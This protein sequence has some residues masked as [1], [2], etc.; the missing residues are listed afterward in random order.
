VLALGPGF[1]LAVDSTGS[2]TASPGQ[3]RL[4]AD[5]SPRPAAPPASSAAAQATSPYAGPV[6]P[7][8]ELGPPPQRL[9]VPDL[10]VIDPA[11]MTDAQISTVSK[12]DGVRAV[13]PA[14]GGQVRVNG[15]PAAVLG[16]LPQEFRSW[17]PPVT[18]ANLAVWAALT[19]G[20]MVTT[21]DAAR[22]LG[23]ATGIA[24]PVSGRD[25]AAIPFGIAAL[26]GVGG[27]DLVMD[28]DRSRQLGLIPDAVLLVNAPSANL[29]ELTRHISRVLGHAAKLVTLIPAATSAIP[30]ATPAIPAA[31]PAIPAATPAGLPVDARVSSGQP[32]GYLQLFQE[33]AARY[34]PGLSWT[35]LAAIG[36]IESGDGSND[37]PSTAGALG[38]MQFMPSTWT[39]WGTDGFGQTG[40][41]D[42][43]NPLDAVPSAAR[44]L[45]AGGAARGGG[46]LPAAIYD[47]N[48]ATWYVTE[49]LQL[50]S[51]Y[52]R[53]YT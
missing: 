25:T 50:A 5:Q 28:E 27:I 37:G 35:I 44:L 17:T 11:G 1:A 41:P 52:A 22:R 30:A 45:C 16:V 18:A 33:S 10:A 53:E 23:L 51:E 7:V 2:G 47:Y 4:A 40:P 46:A 13:L 42:V 8:I 31:T 6:S 20:R 24:Y 36:Q 39:A 15:H 38:P 12:L 26:I 29:A 32:T 48:H 3:Q 43:M 14:A 21:G 49:V 34:C 9:I 19:A